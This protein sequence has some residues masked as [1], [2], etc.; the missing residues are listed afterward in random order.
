MEAQL[1]Y[2]Q[3]SIN[4]AELDFVMDFLDVPTVAG[5]DNLL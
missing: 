2:D 5:S 3:M 1:S 4:G